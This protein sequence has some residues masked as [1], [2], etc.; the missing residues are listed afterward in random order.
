VKAYAMEFCGT[1]AL[2]DAGRELV[3]QFVQHLSDSAQKDRAALVRGSD[4]EC[5]HYDH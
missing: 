5:P 4:S 1:A 3:E 2:K